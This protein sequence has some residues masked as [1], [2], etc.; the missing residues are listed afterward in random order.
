MIPADGVYAA[1]AVIDG[2]SMTAA[3][4]IGTRP[5]FD[6]GHTIEA[7]LLEDVDDLY[8]RE[9]TLQFIERVRDQIKF[10]DAEQLKQKIT[11]DIIKIR[12]IVNID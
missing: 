2:A 3:V 9:M 12:E 5:T 4:S 10:S 8:G 6:G 7:Y 11:E 1:R